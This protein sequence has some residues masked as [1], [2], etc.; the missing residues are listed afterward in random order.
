MNAV[1]INLE[2]GGIFRELS[3]LSILV[4]L[5]FLPLVSFGAKKHKQTS[6][7]LTATFSFIADQ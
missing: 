2:I 5:V 4:G 6:S 7:S 1:F 3:R